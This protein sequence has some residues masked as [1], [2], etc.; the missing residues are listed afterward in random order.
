M[1]YFLET[2]KIKHLK[3]IIFIE[4]DKFLETSLVKDQDLFYYLNLN[5]KDAPTITNKNIL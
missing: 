3:N 2:S 1:I 4:N 5:S